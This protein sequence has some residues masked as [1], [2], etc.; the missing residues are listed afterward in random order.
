[1]M[2]EKEESTL[3]TILHLRRRDPFNPFRIVMASGDRYLI[4]NPDALAVA[5][6]QLHYYP[7]IGNGHSLAAQSDRDR[8]RRK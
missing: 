8:R 1:M 6:A 2:P 5:M 7:A 3:D 4:E